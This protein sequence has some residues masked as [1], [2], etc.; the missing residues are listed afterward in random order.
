MFSRFS[1]L[2][3]YVGLLFSWWL[4]GLQVFSRFMVISCKIFWSVFLDG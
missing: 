1:G 2:W 4:A 3:S